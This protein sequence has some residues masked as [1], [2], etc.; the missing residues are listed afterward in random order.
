MYL[1]KVSMEY[2]IGISMLYSKPKIE[3]LKKTFAITS[4]L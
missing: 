1:S 3:I 4:V 2:G